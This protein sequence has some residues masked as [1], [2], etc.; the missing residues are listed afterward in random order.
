MMA[1]MPSSVRSHADRLRLSALPPCSTSPTSCSIDL[2]L[3]RFESI[4]PPRTWFRRAALRRTSGPA[5]SRGGWLANP[6]IIS[7]FYSSI[8]KKARHARF[9]IALQQIADDRHRRGAGLDH[10]RGVVERDAADRDRRQP[11]RAPRRAAARAPSRGRPRRSRCPWCRCRTPARSRGRRSVRCT[12]RFPLLVRV[13]GQAEDRRRRR[14]PCAHRPA[15]DRPGRRGRRAACDERRDV[16]AIVDDQ[17]RAGRACVVRRWRLA[18]SRK[19]PLAS[20]LQRS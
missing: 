18:R 1:P 13:R 16:G 7:G 20:A 3:N 9:R 19:A 2:V 6:C 8:R 12:A 5:P 15:S 4:P 10:R 14:S 11:L 17:R